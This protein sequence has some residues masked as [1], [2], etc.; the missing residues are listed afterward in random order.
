MLPVIVSNG[1]E[2]SMFEPLVD[3]WVVIQPT[4]PQGLEGALDWV[5][6]SASRAEALSGEPCTDGAVERSIRLYRRRD[7]LARRLEERAGFLG[8]PGPGPLRDAIGSGRFLQVEAHIVLLEWILD[9]KPGIDADVTGEEDGSD[10]FLLLARR[11]LGVSAR[12]D[13]HA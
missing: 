9:E 5:E 11:A 12:Q 1:E 13:D 4:F 10:P 6:S 8:F 2:R 3:E 7:A